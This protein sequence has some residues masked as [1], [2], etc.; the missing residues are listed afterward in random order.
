M[1]I[2]NY[3]FIH[4]QIIFCTNTL[5]ICS[6]S[7]SKSTFAAGAGFFTSSSDSD[8][9]DSEDED[10]DEEDEDSFFLSS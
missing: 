7:V 6:H 1:N 9:D 2:C 10:E 8:D 4:N 5:A 3:H